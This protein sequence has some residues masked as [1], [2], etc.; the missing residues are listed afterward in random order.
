[1]NLDE[2]KNL[3]FRYHGNLFGLYRDGY[4]F[5]KMNIPTEM[6]NA[7]TAE[8]VGQYE[9]IIQRSENLWAVL[10]TIFEYDD[11]SLENGQNKKFIL[12]F[13]LNH[14]NS[15]DDFSKL[16]LCE[17]L[18]EPSYNEYLHDCLSLLKEDIDDLKGKV[19]VGNFKIDSSYYDEGSHLTDEDFEREELQSRVS[20]LT[21][22][23]F[24][25]PKL[26]RKGFF[27]RL[28]HR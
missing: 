20:N 7:W 14:R 2:A 1:M 10:N 25:E 22:K 11:L 24:G 9:N 17:K 13:Y 6:I 27:A 23:F 19:N 5:E 16:L 18:S 26:K 28:F 12:N 15:V 4:D 3:F 8:L 21:E